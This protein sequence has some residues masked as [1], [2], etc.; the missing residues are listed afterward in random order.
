MY[1]YRK[2]WE[3]ETTNSTK[4]TINGPIWLYNYEVPLD[5]LPHFR[6]IGN[7][8]KKDDDDNDEDEEI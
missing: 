2:V 5:K 7:G 3:D 1:T 8:Q 6:R 4:S